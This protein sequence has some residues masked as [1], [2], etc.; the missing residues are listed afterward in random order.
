MARAP[1]S[2]GLGKFLVGLVWCVSGWQMCFGEELQQH[3]QVACCSERVNVAVAV[4][5]LAAEAVNVV[6]LHPLVEGVARDER[7]KSGNLREIVSDA[8]RGAFS[9]NRKETDEAADVTAVATANVLR[10]ELLNVYC[11]CKGSCQ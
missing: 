6:E 8:A 7:A 3:F 4:P 5:E 11:T 1:I 10:V 9:A 2:D